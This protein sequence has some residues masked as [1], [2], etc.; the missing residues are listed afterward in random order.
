MGLEEVKTY[1]DGIAPWKRY[2]VTV[3]ARLDASGNPVDVN[4][5]GAINDSDFDAVANPAW[6]PRSRSAACCC[7]PGP[8]ATSRGD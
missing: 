8:S 5:D 3:K 6:R 2:L 1:A 7:T 4:G